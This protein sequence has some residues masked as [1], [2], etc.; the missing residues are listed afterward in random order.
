MS[1]SR[2]NI[3]QTPLN[4]FAFEESIGSPI[5]NNPYQAVS[6]GLEFVTEVPIEEGY[7]SLGNSR[8]AQQALQNHVVEQQGAMDLI[9]KGVGRTI[10]KVGTEILKTPGYVGGAAMGISNELFGDGK[11]SMSMMVD[12]SWVNA[13]ESLDEQTK[14]LMPVHISQEIQDGNI[15]DK[16]GSGA[17]WATQ[18]ADGVGFMLSMFV[19]G[20]I[21]K[22]AGSGKALAG[23][24]EV[25]ANTKLGKI[26]AAPKLLGLSPEVAELAGQARA[27]QAWINGADG[28]VAATVNTGL[29]AAAEAAGT[30]DNTYKGLK[31]KIKAGE[32]SDERAREI[33]G[34]K[35]S[36]V[37]K[38]NVGL[39]MVSNLLEQAW[40]WKAFGSNADSVIAKATKDGI[41]DY[42]ALRSQANKSFKQTVKEYTSG[43]L[44]NAA[45]EGVFEEGL[46]TQIEQNIEVGKTGSIQAGYDLLGNIFGGK[47]EF[48]EN[49]ELHE[50]M[51]LGSVL[52]SGMG[53]VGQVKENNNLDRFLNGYS[54]A[55]S[56]DKW[57]NKLLKKVG[58]KQDAPDQKGIINILEENFI[59][60]FKGDL[61]NLQT[62]GK[63]DPNK[64]YK[65]WEDGKKEEYIHAMYDSAVATGDEIGRQKWGLLIAQNYT[66]PFLGQQGMEKVF[67]D[68][69]KNELTPVWQ[70]RFQKQNGRE[71]T[72][73]ETTQFQEDF[74]KSGESVFNAYNEA[75][76]TN[77]PERFIKPE[78]GSTNQYASFRQ[79]YFN[80]KLQTL[81]EFESLK[82][83][84]TKADE[85][86]RRLNLESKVERLD[87]FGYKIKDSITAKEGQQI[88]DYFKLLKEV[89]KKQI[90]TN[91]NYESLFDKETVNALYDAVIKDDL[92][93][94]EEVAKDTSK[95]KEEV[96]TKVESIAKKEEEIIKASEPVDDEFVS[97][98]SSE[99]DLTDATDK[100]F[101]EIGF[102]KT[103]TVD[104][105]SRYTASLINVDVDRFL[106][107]LGL[108][109]SQQSFTRD[110][111]DAGEKYLARIAK[112]FVFLNRMSD[113]PQPEVQ[114]TLDM[115]FRHLNELR[116]NV[117]TESIVDTP[118][119]S[120]KV[121]ITR[122]SVPVKKTSTGEK[123]E[124]TVTDTPEGTRIGE[125]TDE[126][127]IESRAEDFTDFQLIDESAKEVVEDFNP[128]DF[129]IIDDTRVDLSPTSSLPDE[130][131]E[132]VSTSDLVE[133]EIGKL[134][135][136]DKH[137]SGV[138]ASYTFDGMVYKDNLTPEG[139]PVLG[140]PAQQRWFKYVDQMEITE[141]DTIVVYP[142]NK[143]KENEELF[144][145]I[146]KEVSG[147]AILDTD[148]WSVLYKN[149]Q[150]VKVDG[151]FVFTSIQRPETTYK[152]GNVR[153]A[154]SHIDKFPGDTYAEK[155]RNAQSVYEQWY[156]GFKEPAE[157]SINEVT[158]GHMVMRYDDLGN[159][160][161]NQA[162][163]NIPS[164]VY[165]VVVS[166]TGTVDFAGKIV[167]VNKGD[168]VAISN[169]INLYPLRVRNINKEE[170]DMIVHMLSLLNEQ[171]ADDVVLDVSIPITSVK[172]R[173]SIGVFTDTEVPLFNY[174]TRFSK[175][176]GGFYVEGQT[177]VYHPYGQEQRT[178]ALA[179][180]YKD[181]E[182]LRDF[183]DF[184]LSKRK[185]FNK[186]LV[187]SPAVQFA[188]VKG[189]IRSI[190]IAG[191]YLSNALEN[192]LLT[193][194]VVHPDY[195]SRLQKNLY[196]G[197]STGKTV[198][199]ETMKS[200]PVKKG[201]K[202]ADRNKKA[203]GNLDAD[204]VFTADELLQIK[205]Q[206]GEI[207]K[208]CK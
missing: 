76:R 113:V 164:G 29:E 196:I 130:P 157:V 7:S 205:L 90:E 195:P 189:T 170:A 184:L 103:W 82:T 33:A 72:Q 144:A 107:K 22:L 81:L 194:S 18:G 56:E 198:A 64:M 11:D 91:Q 79:K 97:V 32:M 118:I 98:E 99:P 87:D 190:P 124:L 36:S 80:A 54:K 199:Q 37:F 114:K 30:F 160:I 127:F 24:A 38:S 89:N 128:S 133:Q 1:K 154:N 159:V 204:K 6:N 202:Y 88:Q 192:D 119:P 44:K 116:E 134:P 149:G 173:N 180:L 71:A 121:K 110:E 39:L 10:A 47:D 84:K 40:V 109:K 100:I 94:E 45:K 167:N 5:A 207:T 122:K 57:Y 138:N 129:Q 125:L 141:A 177:I 34:E 169:D 50:A 83:V 51:V 176:E 86:F 12:N 182:S 35:A 48:W 201:N 166:E 126:G 67:G 25:I 85:E 96:K 31:D 26:T 120:E 152:A 186:R 69:V 8:Y 58:V 158:K 148:L 49:T 61:T 17:W 52:G 132:D 143:I 14:A 155:L 73:E 137:T 70:D 117:D 20:A 136:S 9:A 146:S 104:D 43:G 95:K 111:L 188:F 174:F 2:I 179:D 21:A 151:Q 139:L 23:L 74:T 108:P 185:A 203:S 150:P 13:F 19:P 197:R 163:T 153:V 101:F 115:V 193:M 106:N 41:I 42:N 181:S 142:F 135:I 92:N 105:V 62:D 208:T 123:K 165:Q 78:K 59:K 112:E 46:Q 15:L 200:E 102:D 27:G 145:Q 162:S 131:L 55:E 191:T 161:W 60:N 93:V 183:K 16:M 175:G 68:H 4:P 65:A 53:F 147:I 156:Y 168:V 178:I 140:T 171:S 3:Q 187:E 75:T 172:S 63:L 66:Q 28:I 206:S 77:Y